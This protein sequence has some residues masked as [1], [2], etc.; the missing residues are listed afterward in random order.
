MFVSKLI[1][2]K[3]KICLVQR[4]IEN[5]EF[6]FNYIQQEMYKNNTLIFDCNQ[7]KKPF[8]SLGPPCVIVDVFFFKIVKETRQ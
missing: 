2:F 6:P 5:E 4:K 8:V 1:K 3:K 7:T